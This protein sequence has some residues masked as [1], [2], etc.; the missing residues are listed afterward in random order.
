LITVSDDSVSD[1]DISDR[2]TAN[3]AEPEESECDSIIQQVL[4]LDLLLP[5]RRASQSVSM[6]KFAM[7][8]NS[9]LLRW[10]Q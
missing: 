3:D 6:S 2:P 8:Q 7:T 5:W 1:Q 9:I 4:S 10:L